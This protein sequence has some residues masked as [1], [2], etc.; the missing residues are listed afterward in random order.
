MNRSDLEKQY[1]ELGNQLPTVYP[2]FHFKNHCYWRIAL[3]QVVGDQWNRRLK[4]PAYKN[5][6]DEQLL[7]TVNYMKAYQSDEVLLKQHNQES[8]SWRGKL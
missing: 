8:L 7:T 5:L 4:S 6:S 1:L 2:D 3:D